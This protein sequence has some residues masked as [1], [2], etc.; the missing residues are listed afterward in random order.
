M[1]ETLL[2]HGGWL[3]TGSDG[4]SL[5]E[6]GAI[7]CQGQHITAVGNYTELKTRFPGARETG[8]KS[9]IVLP[10]LINSHHHGRGIDPQMLGSADASLEVWLAGR[11]GEPVVDPYL[12]TL[13]A[14]AN[15][16]ARGVTTVVHFVLTPDADRALEHASARLRAWQDA[17]IRVAL[18][19]DIRQQRFWGYEQEEQ[20]LQGMAPAHSRQ[21]RLQ[22]EKRRILTG[23]EYLDVFEELQQRHS[24]AVDTRFFFAPSGPQ[25]VQDETLSLIAAES[26]SRGIP[27]HTH[28]LETPY[29]REAAQKLYGVP[30]VAHLEQLG[31]LGPLTSLVHAVWVTENEIQLLAASG[32]NVIH[33][34]GSN[35]RLGSGI[36]PLPAML[37]AGINIALG[38]DG[39][40]LGEDDLLAEARLAYH[41]HRWPGVTAP[42][43]ARQQIL[44]ALTAGAAA[45]TPFGAEIGTLVPG[46]FADATVVDL[47]A[48]GAP[49][50]SADVSPLE[51]LLQR[52]SGRH[53]LATIVSG[54]VLAE[55]GSPTRVDLPELARELARSVRHGSRELGD[56]LAAATREHYRDRWDAA[57]VVPHWPRNGK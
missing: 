33:N 1:V 42:Q 53:V 57:S 8:S 49:Y 24:T 44:K 55:N 6:D 35:L 16:L 43:P 46:A 28:A 34:P 38:T 54:E 36:S 45:V 5:I 37:D 4:D 15:L 40:T 22:Q 2:I 19:L 48:A 52:A 14:A 31:L 20:F 47:E 13:W 51:V 32:T 39:F 10:G 56:S 3:W 30:L 12:D 9:A 17:G 27:V 50:V 18:G 21:A 41:L 29:Q 23:A 26:E 11:N 7:A 25:W